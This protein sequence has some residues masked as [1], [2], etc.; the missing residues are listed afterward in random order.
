M[1]TL[2]YRITDAGLLFISVPR[3]RLTCAFEPASAKWPIS[4]LFTGSA[5]GRIHYSPGPK[6]EQRQILK[7]DF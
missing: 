5:N 6:L 4:L 3:F 1:G 7:G 2:V